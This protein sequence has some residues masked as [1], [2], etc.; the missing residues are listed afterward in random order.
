[1]VLVKYLVYNHLKCKKFKA[2]IKNTNKNSQKLFE[3]LKFIKICDN[4][5]FNECIYQLECNFIN[6]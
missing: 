5:R 2:I 6:L 4:N 1:M 3:K